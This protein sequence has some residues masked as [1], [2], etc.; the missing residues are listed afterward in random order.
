[1]IM[2]TTEL[3]ERNIPHVVVKGLHALRPKGLDLHNWWV[4]TSRKMV[5]NNNLRGFRQSNP[6]ENPEVKFARELNYDEIQS[7]INQD[8]DHYTKYVEPI[9][10]LY[11]YKLEELKELVKE[12]S[13]KVKKQRK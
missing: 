8:K 9:G 10:D 5:K 3:R 7:F 4:V 11:A 1:M 12:E 2:I 13:N 6:E